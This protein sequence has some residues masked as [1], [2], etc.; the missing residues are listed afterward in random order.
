MPR[1]PT[2]PASDSAASAAARAF[3]FAE[4]GAVATPSGSNARADATRARW[5]LGPNPTP[6]WALTPAAAVFAVAAAFLARTSTVSILGCFWRIRAWSSGMTVLPPGNACDG[7]S[8]PECALGGCSV[9]PTRAHAAAHAA[10]SDTRSAET[11]A[12]NATSESKNSG[13]CAP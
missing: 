12:G 9:V 4:D 11:S 7:L 5:R 3:S 1:V 8:W 2:E 10:A 13:R 6:P